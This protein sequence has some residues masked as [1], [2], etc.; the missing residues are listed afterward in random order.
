M[1]GL[2][3]VLLAAG[4]SLDDV[5]ALGVPGVAVVAVLVL[6]VRPL[7]V[8]VCTL[9]SELSLR[10]RALVAWIAPR[11]IVAAAVA[12][13]TATALEAAGEPGGGELRALVFMTIAGTVALAGVTALPVASLLGVRLPG[14]ERVGILGIHGLS[15]ALGSALRE[16]GT[17]VVFLD[18]NPQSCRRVEDADFPVVF[19]DAL[20]ERTLQRARFESVGTLIGMT[21]N[22]ALNLQFVARAREFFHVP[23]CLVALRRRDPDPLDDIV[24]LFLGDHDLERWDVR[25]RHDAVA[26][27]P[28]VHVGE[29]AEDEPGEPLAARDERFVVLA[30]RRGKQVSPVQRGWSPRRDDVVSVAVHLP[31]R[32]EAHARLRELGFAPY[33]GE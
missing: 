25:G 11:G 31:E 21:P 30:A 14:R 17:P 24:P 16:A 13:L 27:E 29:A 4:V 5:R 23:R 26:I 33:E 12:A 2:L 6:L 3:F 1:V 8:A 32:D 28:W 19:G 9:R 7:G 22:D 18:S 20:Q 10:E 15:L